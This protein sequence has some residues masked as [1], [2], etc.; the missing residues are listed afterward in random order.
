MKYNNRNPLK[1]EATDETVKKLLLSLYKNSMVAFAKTEEGK[2][3]KLE[4]QNIYEQRR[5]II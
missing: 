5:Y 2:A 4:Y 1:P 3:T